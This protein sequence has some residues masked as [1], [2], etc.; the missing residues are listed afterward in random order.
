MGDIFDLI[1]EEQWKQEAQTDE[2]IQNMLETHPFFMDSAPLPGEEN[3]YYDAMMALKE[4]ESPLTIAENFK[5]SG[6]LAFKKGPTRYQDAITYYT[7][8]LD[9]NCTD[10]S[11]NSVIFC[12]RALVQLSLKNYAKTVDDCNKAIVLDKDNVKAYYRA[13]KAL[14]CINKYEECIKRCRQGLAV[15]TDAGMK[16]SLRAV[17]NDCKEKKVKYEEEEKAKAAKKRQDD[18][19]K[20]IFQEQCLR[21]GITFVEDPLY[22]ISDKYSPNHY[23]DTRTLHWSVLIL[24]PEY[25]MSDFVEAWNEMITLEEMIAQILP[26]N[27]KEA[28]QQIEYPPWDVKQEYCLENVCI[29]IEGDN[30]KLVVV[31][32]SLTLLEC[33]QKVQSFKGMPTLHI[34]LG[35]K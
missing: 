21:R 27:S 6:N 5:E 4:D 7:N 23:M 18:L 33:L 2:Q 35:S 11:L 28:L 29:K 3:P 30:D 1:D 12:N 17:L 10:N 15:A 34:S 25:E 20:E 14:V 22:R 32:P 8:A 9:A 19:K 26:S 13:G 24:Y 16:K 31:H